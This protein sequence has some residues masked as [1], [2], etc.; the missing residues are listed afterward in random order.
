MNKKVNICGLEFDNITLNEAVELIDNKLSEEKKLVNSNSAI[1][2]NANFVLIANQDIIN[3]KMYFSQLEDE[4]LNRAYLITADGY[5]IIYAAKI[6]G[7]RLKER[8]A[9]PDLMEKLIELSDKKGYI[10][11]FLGSKEDVVIKMLDNFKK[12]YPNFK[13]GGFYSPP[14][15]D[16]FSEEENNKIISFIN[17]SNCDILWVSFGC[18]KQER[19]IIENIE[20]LDVFLTIGIGAAFDFH[21]GFLKRAPKIIQNLRLEWFYRFLQEPKRLFTRYFIGG[22]KFLNLVLKH[23]RYLKNKE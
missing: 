13:I 22:F 3:K 23:K 8:I 16:V 6:L 7:Y 20:R 14:F 5:S 19:W 17:N 15:C 12:K 11:F 9:G 4:K 2:K 1:K 10:N 21:S 18:P